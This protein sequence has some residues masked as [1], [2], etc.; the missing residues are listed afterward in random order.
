MS[1][2]SGQGRMLKFFIFLS[3]CLCTLQHD[4]TTKPCWSCE[5]GSKPRPFCAEP[6]HNACCSCEGSYDSTTHLC[7]EGKIWSRDR[8][9]CCTGDVYFKPNKCCW[10]DGGTL[11]HHVGGPNDDAGRRNG[12]DNNPYYRSIQ[13]CDKNGGGT[14]I[15]IIYP[16]GSGCC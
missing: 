14:G 9:G 13:C 15:G 12:T 2:F 5:D 1:L 7:C 4:C 16:K 11:T 8:F 6:E 3:I 10:G